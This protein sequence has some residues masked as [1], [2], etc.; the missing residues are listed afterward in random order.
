VYRH[1]VKKVMSDYRRINDLS[2]LQAACIETNNKIYNNNNNHHHHP[3]YKAPKALASESLATG[4][5]WVL[6]SLTEEVNRLQTRITCSHNTHSEY[7]SNFIFFTP[8]KMF[9][10]LNY[11]CMC[12]MLDEGCSRHWLTK[13]KTVTITFPQATVSFTAAEKN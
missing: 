8:Y 13:T 10:L 2:H 7:G 1:I 5:L 6:I 12:P 4:Q 3:I 11:R 9:Y